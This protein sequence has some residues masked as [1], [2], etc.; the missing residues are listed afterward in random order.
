MIVHGYEIKKGANLRCADLNGADLNGA[1]LRCTNLNGANLNG[2]DL[3]NADLNYAYLIGANLRR[4]HLRGADLSNSILINTNLYGADLSEAKGIP[5][6][7]YSSLQVLPDEGDVVGFKKCLDGVM[8]KLLIKDGTPR[9]NATTRKCRAKFATVLEVF[10]SDVG[11][12]KHDRTTKYIKGDTVFCDEWC[13][14]RWKECAGG[15]HFFITRKEA[16]DY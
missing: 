3:N 9:S 15:I 2:A 13:E 16:E 11:I 10:G 12:S 14:D 8:V 5:D 1:D 7:I 6:Y 4:A